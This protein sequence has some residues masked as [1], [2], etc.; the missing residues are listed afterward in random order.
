MEAKLARL[1]VAARAAL[2]FVFVYH[3]LA[4]KILWLSPV[5]AALASAHGLDPAFV[6]PMAGMLEVV[7]GIALLAW[8][9]SLWPVYVAIAA[10]VVLLLDVALVMP[11]L[12]IEAFN[13]VTVNV[14]ALFIGYVVIV[15]Q[16]HPLKPAPQPD[17]AV[18]DAARRSAPR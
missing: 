12:L 3:G 8:R 2:A 18:H 16:G 17:G 11:G 9:T 15:T 4:P 6:S 14:S 5:E 10:L 13:P 1:H 7:L